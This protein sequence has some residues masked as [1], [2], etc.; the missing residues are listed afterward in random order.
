MYKCITDVD[1]FPKLNL[2]RDEDKDLKGKIG[3]FLRFGC[4]CLCV[5]LISSCQTVKKYSLSEQ[6][7]NHYLHAENDREIQYSHDMEKL[8]IDF[9]LDKMNIGIGRNLNKNI[10]ANCTAKMIL[11]FPN[12]QKQLTL[13]IKFSGKPE[14][15]SD[16]GAVYLATIYIDD[17]QVHTK[18]EDAD[19]RNATAQLD[20]IMQAYFQKYPIYLVDTSSFLE[21]QALTGS[22]PF[23]VEK[24]HLM[25]SL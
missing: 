20:K 6:M 19:I 13:N 21:K 7:V 22:A 14:L 23:V 11:H 2:E 4:T 16:R 3:L 24:G 12:R 1:Y 10:S 8:S 5:L 17:Y 15:R 9:S 25:F 18:K